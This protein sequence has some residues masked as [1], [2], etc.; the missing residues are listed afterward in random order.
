[1]TP[2]KVNFWAKARLEEQFGLTEANVLA[3]WDKYNP[4]TR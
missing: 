1:M 4:Y 3:D 2:T